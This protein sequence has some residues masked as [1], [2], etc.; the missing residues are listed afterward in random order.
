[1]QDAAEKT[2]RSCSSRPNVISLAKVIAAAA[3]WCLLHIETNSLTAMFTAC[4]CRRNEQAVLSLP[5][6]SPEGMCCA[7]VAF[8]VPT[9]WLCQTPAQG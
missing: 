9:E 8:V 3:S 1:M 7:H 5:S 6:L 4:H 2:K